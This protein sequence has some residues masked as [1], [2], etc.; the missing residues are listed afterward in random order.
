M[1]CSSWACERVRILLG[2]FVLGGLR[3]QEES[4]V[5]THL[6]GCARCQAEC[7]E[8]ADVPD[9]LDLAIS[10]EAAQAEAPPDSLA[11]QQEGRAFVSGRA[12]LPR[13]IAA[14]GHRCRGPSLP[15]AIAAAGHRCRGPSLPRA[16]AASADGFPP[17]SPPAWPARAA[18][19]TMPNLWA[20]S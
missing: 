20:C 5:T 13:A 16:I 17:A 12:S 7:E 2:V 14:A 4:L 15:R 10:E 8:L 6:A 1:T 11:L 9:L 3:G 19:S 18:R